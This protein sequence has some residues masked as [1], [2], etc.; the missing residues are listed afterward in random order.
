MA[1]EEFTGEKRESLRNHFEPDFCVKPKV[2]RSATEA[3]PSILGLCP[4]VLW[5]HAER[6]FLSSSEFRFV[7]SK[8]FVAIYHCFV[9]RFPCSNGLE[10]A[11]NL[12]PPQV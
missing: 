11:A 6:I 8:A 10:V 3:G 9:L 5:F 12:V 7:Y 2:I 4:V 1:L